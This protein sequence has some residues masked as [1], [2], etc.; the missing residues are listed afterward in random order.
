MKYL[1]VYSHE[2]GFGSTDCVFRHEP[3]TIDDIRCAEKELLKINGFKCV[4]MNWLK[5]SDWFTKLGFWKGK[6]KHENKNS[7]N[8]Y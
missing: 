3:P 4:I 8:Y 1:V 5:I 6:R 2:R 7:R